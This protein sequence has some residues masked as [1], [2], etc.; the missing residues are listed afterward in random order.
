MCTRTAAGPQ[1]A[2]GAEDGFMVLYS[3]AASELYMTAF[4]VA[5]LVQPCGRD[6]SDFHTRKWSSMRGLL[7]LAE[8][9]VQCKWKTFCIRKM[10][11]W[12]LDGARDIH[13]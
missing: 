10:S 7:L 12:T 4:D 6:G 8:L 11:D 9:G 1:Q 3:H 2:G 13:E 5:I